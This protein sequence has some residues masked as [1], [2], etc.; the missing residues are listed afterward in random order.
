MAD[1]QWSISGEY[2]ESCNCDYLCP[3][4][5]TNPQGEATHEHCIALMIF[6]IDEGKF[7]ETDLTGV[8]FALI[9]RSGRVMADGDWLFGGVVDESADE[10]QRAALSAIIGGEAGGVPGMIQAGL[11]T[12]YKGVQFHAIDF[13]QDDHKRS[14]DIPGLMSY[15]IE[16]VLS[17]NGGGETYY[18]DNT[19]HPANRRLALARTAHVRIDGF[20]LNLDL[21]GQG[22]NGHF[23]PFSWSA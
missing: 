18:I 10:A 15:A 2:M 21:Q 4:I 5:Y 12:D 13:V 16:G 19:G 6:R 8:K 7:G 22:N 11:V 1:Q 14:V 23:A 3:C 17:R 20:G 9:I